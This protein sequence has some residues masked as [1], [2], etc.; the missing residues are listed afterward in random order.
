MGKRTCVLSILV[1]LAEMTVP[2]LLQ[3]NLSVAALLV[4][5]SSYLVNWVVLGGA[6][7]VTHAAATDGCM[8]HAALAPSCL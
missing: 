6:Q 7:L 3:H 8:L 5:T 4:P 2:M 1:S